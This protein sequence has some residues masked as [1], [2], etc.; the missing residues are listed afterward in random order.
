MHT[1]IL[2]SRTRLWI[3]LCDIAKWKPSWSRRLKI[4][5]LF[6]LKKWI[7][8]PYECI[9]N[10]IGYSFRNIWW[11]FNTFKWTYKC[12][13]IKEFRQCLSFWIKFFSIFILY[14]IFIW[15]L[16]PKWFIRKW[17]RPW[18]IKKKIKFY[19]SVFWKLNYLSIN[20]S[21]FLFKT[22]Q[23]GAIVRCW[24]ASND[25]GNDRWLLLDETGVDVCC[26]RLLSFK[27]P[28]FIRER[29]RRRTRLHRKSSII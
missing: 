3:L 10:N 28:D 7:D 26:L 6:F 20:R 14:I 11:M 5:M 12:S 18:K 9:K 4:E 2:T 24:I 27:F 22:T 16:N 25:C 8:L 1:F 23:H 15:F 21:I 29:G 19:L 17:I 13:Y